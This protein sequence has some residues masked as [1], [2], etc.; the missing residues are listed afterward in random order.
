MFKMLPKIS[1]KDYIGKEL[2]TACGQEVKDIQQSI[3]CD[4]CLRWTHRKCCK[5][6]IKKFRMLSK[7]V[8]FDW[9]CRMCREDDPQYENTKP[10]SVLIITEKNDIPDSYEI[11]KK[12][13]NDLL[14]IHLNCR[15]LIKKLEEL[16]NIIDLL[17][18]DILCLSETWL[19]NS[20]PLN[21]HIPAGYN[22]IR[23]DR[24]E[25]FQ[26]KYKKKHGG[27]TAIIYKSYL[28]L[29]KKKVPE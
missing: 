12:S 15:S 22:I 20:V 18:P 21:S 28:Y 7:K 23:K 16:Q 14:I 25:D 13:K 19:D 11:V 1:S 10:E 6:T 17:N 26:I 27:G 9:F 2:C 8:N 4:N 29:V 3:S 5:I 24:T